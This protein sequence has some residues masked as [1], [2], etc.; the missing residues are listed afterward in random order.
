MTGKTICVLERFVRRAGGERHPE[1]PRRVRGADQE[2]AALTV[3]PAVALMADSSDASVEP[4]DRRRAGQ[5]AGGHDDPRGRQAGR[6]ARAALLLPPVAAGRRRVPDVPGRGRE[7]AQARAGLRD[8]G[9]RRA[10]RAR[11]LASRRSRRRKGVLEILLINHPLDCPICDQA[12][13]CELQDYTFQEGRAEARY[14][15]TPSASIR[16]RTSAATCCTSPNRCILCTRCVRFMED[17]AD[18]PVLNV[19]ERGDR[20]FIGSS[21]GQRPRPSVGRQRGRPLPGRLAALQGLPAQ[22]AR[23]GAGQDRVGLHRA[24]RRAAT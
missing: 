22:G 16:S 15:D 18:D 3:V 12:G 23:L 11:P 2:E 13:E 24:A 21:T 5:R 9:G 17:V 14:R 19:S 10:G 4:D 7:G 8:G 1:V 20:A 6:R